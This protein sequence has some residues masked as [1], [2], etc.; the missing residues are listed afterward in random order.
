MN[1]NQI[2]IVFS[3]TREFD[4]SP[5]SIIKYISKDKENAINVFNEYKNNI[6]SLYG[7]N[8]KNE[9]G[10]DNPNYE[11]WTDEEQHIEILAN[12]Y[13]YE[14]FIECFPVDKMI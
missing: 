2:Y 10:K 5:N 9:A 12:N 13:I 7:E 3:S 4:D 11:I 6:L 8:I 1:N 14:Y